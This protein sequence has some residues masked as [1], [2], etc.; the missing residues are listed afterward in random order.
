MG[1]KFKDTTDPRIISLYH[2]HLSGMLEKRKEELEK[3]VKT[4]E[5]VF[6]SAHAEHLKA[7]PKQKYLSEYKMILDHAKDALR[8]LGFLYDELRITYIDYAIDCAIDL[9]KEKI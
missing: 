8:S 9:L 1:K 2:F 5:E 3:T 7:N 6:Y 4:M